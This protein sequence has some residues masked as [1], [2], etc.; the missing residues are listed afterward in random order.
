MINVHPYITENQEPFIYEDQTL[1]Y[2]AIFFKDAFYF[3]GSR[4]LGQY[5][6]IYYNGFFYLAGYKPNTFDNQALIAKYSRST[7]L[8]LATVGT[9]TTP[10]N[11]PFDH[12]VPAIYVNQITGYVYLIQNKYHNSSFRIFKSDA[13]ETTNLSLVGE[14]ISGSSYITIVETNGSDITFVTRGYP[15]GTNN[16]FYCFSCCTVNLDTLVNTHTR[17]TSIDFATNQ[18]RHYPNSTP[19]YV[20]GTPT[21]YFSSIMHRYEVNVLPY[22][23]SVLATADWAIFTNYANTFSKDVISTSAITEAEL[24][25]NY[26]LVGTDT[27]KTVNL[28]PIV[29]IQIDD[30]LFLIHGN[31]VSNRLLLNKITYGSATVEAFEIPLDSARFDQCYMYY[32]GSNIIITMALNDGSSNID[33]AIF[34][35]AAINTD[36]TGYYLFPDL[37]ETP[38]AGNANL[39]TNFDDVP[40]GTYYPIMGARK[41]NQLGMI[42]YY[43]SNRNWSIW[44]GA[45][46]LC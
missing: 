30:S 18:V 19:I 29:S 45:E 39:V 40:T 2:K 25:T 22:K 15:G 6:C 38:R 28:N 1:E 32:N 17:I 13:P 24:E 44:E 36:L 8:E 5:D 31:D 21:V 33:N 4:C 34:R 35:I 27:D 11:E 10:G 37:L 3:G 46:F 20:Y 23:I 12:P 7:G 9:G 26:T 41:L 16:D 43:E 14:I 42:S